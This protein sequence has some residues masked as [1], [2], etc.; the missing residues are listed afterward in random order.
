M[1]DF[2]SYSLDRDEADNYAEIPKQLQHGAFF[3]WQNNELADLKS[4]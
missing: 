4:L 2:Y 3:C 1:T